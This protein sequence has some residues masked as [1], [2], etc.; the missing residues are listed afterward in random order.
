MKVVIVLHG[1]GD[2]DYIN[3]VR[4]FAGRINVSYA[5]V[6]HVKPLVNEVI[7]DIYIP[8]FVGYGSDYD[9]AVSIIGYASPPLLDWPGIR[10]FLISLG[11]GLYVFHGDDDPRFIREIGNLDLGNTAFLAIKPGLAELLG[12]YCP[13]KVI[14]ILFTNGVI[15]KRVL[16]VTKSLCPSTYVE[17]PLFELESFINYFMKSLGWLIS[18]TKCLR[19]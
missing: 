14:P 5:F 13:D 15:Y 10:E 4:N 2:P 19:C 9:K 16:D 18:N 6:S 11:P 3:D 17:R 7:G 12:R 8:L 1:S